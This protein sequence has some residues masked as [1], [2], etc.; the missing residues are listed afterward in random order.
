MGYWWN[1]NFRSNWGK[2][3][4]AALLVDLHI[5]FL[6][7]VQK[8]EKL[9]KGCW[10]PISAIIFWK[11][12]HSKGSSNSARICFSSESKAA[13]ST[14]FKPAPKEVQLHRFE[15]DMPTLYPVDLEND[16]WL[17]CWRDPKS[18]TGVA[19]RGGMSFEF[20]HRSWT[21]VSWTLQI[22]KVFWFFSII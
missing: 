15:V 18:H 4:W 3:R 13:S 2:G 22:C 12:N 7:G 16:K 9:P 5:Y 17:K 14:C 20:F 19:D 6:R 11:K 8:N 10:I 1:K 21:G